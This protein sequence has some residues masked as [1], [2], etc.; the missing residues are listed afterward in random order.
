MALESAE[1]FEDLVATN[2]TDTDVIREGDDHVRTFKKVLKQVMPGVNLNGFNAPILA[3]ETEWNYLQGV[4][5]KIQD[6]LNAISP[7]QVPIG[8]L[9][10]Y[11]GLIAA[12]PANYRIC[13]GTAGTPNLVDRFIFGTTTEAL[14]E[15][16]GGTS[17]S[18]I[19]EHTHNYVHS[20]TGS[21][22][23]DGDHTHSL[24]AKSRS[25]LNTLASYAETRTADE[26]TTT[27]GEHGHSF[28]VD[29]TMV[30]IDSAGGSGVGQNI[31]PFVKLAYVQR[32]S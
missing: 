13:D 24:I 30:N 28:T 21:T 10:A 8:C 20:H 17:D 29:S 3:T 22:T 6:Q 11:V 2:P 12:I 31:P 18:V 26:A 5:S 14:L 27:D 9:T 19:A 1:N 4:T 25:G 7:G 15:T 16:T 23:T 32:I